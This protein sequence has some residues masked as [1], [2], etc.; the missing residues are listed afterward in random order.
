MIGREAELDRIDAFLS[1]SVRS[2]RPLLLLG[3]AGVGKTALL[4]TA[5]DRAAGRGMRV[6]AATG[7]EYRARLSYG[8]LVQLLGS[9]T[10]GQPSVV[11]GS[12][13]TAVQ[14]RGAGP[15]PHHD[16]VAEGLLSVLRQLSDRGPVLLAVDDVQWLDP[17]G[18][19]VL[20]QV[21]RRLDGTGELRVLRRAAAG[22]CSLT[23]RGPP[24]APS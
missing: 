21:A 17:A 4:A 12:A 9:V 6:L 15:A 20:G 10:A 1:G 7:V 11:L 2:G 22:R 8:G 23:P 18:A 3:D 13:L 19:E 5:A 24:N 14:G 16:A